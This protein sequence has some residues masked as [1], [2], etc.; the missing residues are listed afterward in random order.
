MGEGPRIAVIGAGIGGLSAAAILARRFDVDVYERASVPGG[1]V[2][3]ID[4]A[5]SKIDSGPTVFTMDWAFQ[6]VM[7]LAGATLEDEVTLKKLNVLARH[8]W[9][10]GSTLDLFA[11]R[12]QSAAAIAE[13]AGPRE[14]DNYRAFCSKTRDVYETLRDPFLRAQRPSFAGLIARQ[15]PMALLNTSPFSTLWGALSRSFQDPRLRQLFG[16]YATYCGASPFR[17]PATLMLIAH[18]EQE[19]V[20]ALDGGMQSIA[21]ALHR[22][23]ER[24][25]VTYHFDA[26]V[27]AVHESAGRVTG[28]QLASGET[29]P[30][31]IIVMNGDASA[32][33]KGHLGPAG[34]AALSLPADMQRSQSAMT[35]SMVAEPKGAPL[36]MHTVFFSDDY[37]A[38][39][40]AV[41]ERGDVPN[42]PTTYICAPDRAPG[43]PI[44]EGPERLF[45]LINAPP[46][47]D[48]HTYAA[49]EIA[50][51]Q[52]RMLGLLG[53]C[54]LTLSNGPDTARATT[55]TDFNAMFPATGGALYGMASH[56]WRASFQRPSARS[57]LTGLYLAGGSVHPGP[58]APMAAL[59]GKA[60]ALAILQDCGS[61]LPSP[62]AAMP[63]GISTR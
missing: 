13:F 8:Y 29:R 57:R 62:L 7:D 53:R 63:G 31:D 12:E 52:D 61:T 41:F 20:W 35:W 28:L 45:C 10:D 30:A 59:S 2:R 26:H 19:G 5:G 21:K 51:C 17:A 22:V 48:T 54:G 33:A 39:F 6:E 60:A 25:G 56:G 24:N 50:Q 38:E 15:S 23:G 27:E 47:G 11:D 43:L 1:K 4:I 37:G 18:V 49:E 58:G 32:L 46:S 44:P 14:A 40:E 34:R 42:D 55:P 16:R 36:D 3:Q 9:T